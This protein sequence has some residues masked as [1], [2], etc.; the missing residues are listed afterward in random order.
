MDTS[1]FDVVV[2]PESQERE[3]WWREI[4]G[5]SRDAA[6]PTTTPEQRDEHAPPADSARG[7]VQW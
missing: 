1:D 4:L 7:V 6:L 3:A 2:W 5:V